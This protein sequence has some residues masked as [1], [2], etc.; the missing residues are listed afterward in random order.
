VDAKN[1]RQIT[2]LTVA[3]V[4]IVFAALLVFSSIY[5]VN[6]QQEA[7][8]VQFGKAVGTEKA[9]LHFRIPFVQTISLVD[10]T[11]RGM[12]IG[13]NPA[14][15]AHV[16]SESFMITKDFNFVNV[17]FY[18]EWKVSDPTK[19]LFSSKDPVALLRNIMQ[20]EARNVVASYDVDDVLTTAKFEIQKR[21]KEGVVKKVDAYKLGIMIS[22][23]SIQ[24]TEPPTAEV[25]TAFKDVENAKQ[26]KDTEINFAYKYKNEILPAAAAEA[27]R[28]VK[29]AEGVKQS[30]INEATGQVAR[31]NELYAEYARNKDITRTRMYLETMEAVLPGMDVIITD[32]SG[33]VLKLLNLG[34]GGE[35]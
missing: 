33:D 28:I 5:T 34:E 4:I 32:Q 10:M 27:D 3:A 30:R 2:R 22:N 16:E 7:V 35:Q 25:I 24:D 17:D 1:V 18:V 29:D 6:V 19:F 12:E 23:V 11:T 14:N 9:G 31:F 15:N 20:A 21:V 8:I 13:Y 26:N